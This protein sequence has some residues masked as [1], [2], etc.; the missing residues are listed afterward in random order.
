VPAR[1]KPDGDQAEIERL[2][3]RVNKA[4]ETFSI[5]EL[6]QLV[7]EIEEIAFAKFDDDQTQ[8]S[9]SHAGNRKPCSSA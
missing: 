3:E 5:E 9:A 6:R 2:R 4:L 8:P 1:S 7:K